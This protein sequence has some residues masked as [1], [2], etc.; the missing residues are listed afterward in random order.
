MNKC[1]ICTEEINETNKNII[2]CQECYEQNLKEVPTINNSE[3]H[4]NW[5]IL[6]FDQTILEFQEL[7]IHLETMK[8]SLYNLE[9]DINK[10]KE[11]IKNG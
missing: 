4:N 2:C 9:D 3:K 11:I 6:Q 7:K 1:I 8:K 5:L 10:I